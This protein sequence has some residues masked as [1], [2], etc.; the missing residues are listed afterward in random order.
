M[1]FRFFF[2]SFLTLL[3]LCTLTF[4]RCHVNSFL[5]LISGRVNSE[6]KQPSLANLKN[7]TKQNESG[8]EHFRLFCV[9]FFELMF[10]LLT[11]ISFQLFSL[12]SSCFPQVF[13]WN[14]LRLFQCETHGNFES[15][16]SEFGTGEEET[17]V[18]SRYSD[19]HG[20]NPRKLPR[21]KYA[22]V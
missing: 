12:S 14:T 7:K 3:Y 4:K 10:L 13:F 15:C 1:L 8:V 11:N 17:S 22:I 21:T 2:F 18:T 19:L 9:H 20:C 5:F 16:R 6:I